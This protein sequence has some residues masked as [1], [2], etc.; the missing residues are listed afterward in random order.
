MEIKV[1]KYISQFLVNNGIKD[2]FM[3]TG[4]GAMHLDDAIGHQEGMHC[5]FNHHEQACA[6]AAEGYT[7]MTG[8]LA[9]VCVTSGP[10][11]TNAITGVMGGWL[12]SI[13]MFVIS[14]QVKRETT[15]WACSDLNLRQLGDQEF[16]VVDSVKNMT[17]YAV[18]VTNPKEI[19]YHLEKAL[20]L[21][22]NGRCGPVW[23]DIPLDVQGAKIDTDSLIH[24][25]AEEE[26][27]W[28]IPKTKDSAVE[29]LLDRIKN[30]KAPLVLAGTGINV[31]GAQNKLLQFL[32]KYKIPVVT[33]WNANDTVAYDNPYYVGMPGTVGMRSGN[34][35]IQNCDLLISLGCRMNIR[36]IGYTHYDFAKNAFKAVVDID[37]RELIKPTV[38]IDLPINADV[39]EFL[40]R[41]L[42]VDYAPIKEHK[43]WVEWCRNLLFKYPTVREEYH[44]SDLINPY[45]FIDKLFH[46]L[47]NRD[48]II[49]GNGAA[50]VITF[51]A[52]KIKQGQRVFTNSGCAA[53][54][55][56]FP[57]AIGVA[58]SDN[59][60]RTICIDGDG[61][62]M[63]N[64]QELATMAYNK[65]NI[66]LFILNNNGYLSIR[67]TQRN[68]FKPPFIGID[69][70]SGIGFPDFEKLADAFG[71]K[72]F[73]LD[74][75][76]SADAIYQDVLNFEGPCICEAVVDPNQN[77]EPKSSSKVLPDGR[78]VSPSLDDM[79]PFLE[80]E[81]FEKIRYKR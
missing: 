17:K 55:Y 52:A 56:G 23:L 66:K 50:C 46:H 62:V 38:Q 8:K 61:S 12:D 76:K 20:F 2:C 5:T 79:A 40:D 13:P 9:A 10:G 57:A 53:M 34:F 60:N 59:S 73:K 11:G 43:E 72:Y 63:M 69:S 25:D 49:C 7:R 15:I 47:D 74:N 29:I 78:I 48:R 54:G 33:A 6:V 64:I 41:M 19:A 26:V 27:V 35:A 32:D 51:Q 45:V 80:R 36:M 24:F 67:Q 68:L 70:E 37:P 39:S 42:S 16:N 65:L 44:G 81:E 75:E 30:S 14:G 77:F 18:M 58:V 28:R 22:L 3:V 21:A 1:A 31:G 4:G 71:I